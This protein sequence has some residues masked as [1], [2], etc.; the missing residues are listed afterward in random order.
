MCLLQGLETSRFRDG[1]YKLRNSAIRIPLWSFV[2]QLYAEMAKQ[3]RQSPERAQA[4]DDFTQSRG[5]YQ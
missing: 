2:R 5:E 4:S 3:E 1:F